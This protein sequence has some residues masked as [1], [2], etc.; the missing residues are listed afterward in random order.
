MEFDGI[1][2]WY[3]VC[4]SWYFGEWLK[5][6]V[7]ALINDDVDKV[8]LV[9]VYSSEHIHRI[10]CTP[11][12]SHDMSHDVFTTVCISHGI[13]KYWEPWLQVKRNGSPTTGDRGQQVSVST[14]CTDSRGSLGVS[15]TPSASLWHCNTDGLCIYVITEL[16]QYYKSSCR[17]LFES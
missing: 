4:T 2:K 17:M 12:A 7:L 15:W 3:F 11:I 5:V 8:E 10:Q 14:C 9:W 1:W 16:Q 13:K 6:P